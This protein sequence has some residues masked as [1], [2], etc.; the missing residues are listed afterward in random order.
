MNTPSTGLIALEPIL[1]DHLK[2]GKPLFTIEEFYQH[3]NRF[4]FRPLPKKFTTLSI[5]AALGRWPDLKEAVKEQLVNDITQRW[6]NFK[7]E[8]K[9]KPTPAPEQD[10][11]ESGAQTSVEPVE[12]EA[13][14]QPT[15]AKAAPAPVPPALTT[16][17][18]RD[19]FDLITDFVALF[20]KPLYASKE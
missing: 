5:T 11:T 2:D 13:L 8:Q 17:P 6:H 3:L 7:P 14:D 15:P 19:W 20:F 9:E 10:A 1:E 4:T 16:G 12:D 18:K